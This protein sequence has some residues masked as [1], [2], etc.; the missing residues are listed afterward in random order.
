MLFRSGRRG[1]ESA[2]ACPVHRWCARVLLATAAPAGAQPPAT[3]AFRRDVQPIFR[4][5]CGSCHGQEMQM[6]G[7]RLDRRRDALRGG[8]QTDI[9]PE[10]RL[11]RGGRPRAPVAD[12]GAG[13]GELGPRVPAARPVVGQR[14]GR[15][16]RPGRARA[17]RGATCGWR[18]GTAAIAGQRRLRH[19]TGDGGAARE[20]VD[21]RREPG[22]PQR[23]RIP[24]AHADRGRLLDRRNA[25]YR[26]RPTSRAA[27][28]TAS[29]SGSPPPP[30]H[31]R[32]R[33][34][35]S[36]S[37]R[38]ATVRPHGPAQSATVQ[39]AYGRLLARPPAR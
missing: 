24:A 1:V 21:R 36:R 37:S 17:A 8:S 9:A 23:R 14:A 3:I 25:R 15:R 18:V 30:P 31:G 4:D 10:R 19:R 6:G 27:F 11:R 5:R 39:S 2:H 29:T 32:R 7:R 13:G 28:P 16:A 38:G 33:R 26:S 20:P 22:V 35:R 34:S 12:D